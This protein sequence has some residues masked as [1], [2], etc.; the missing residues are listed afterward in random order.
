M[1]RIPRLSGACI[2][3]PVTRLRR[4]KAFRLWS[5]KH[6]YIIALATPLFINPMNRNPNIQIEFEY[7]PSVDRIWWFLLH[8]H[9][10]WFQATSQVPVRVCFEVKTM[11]LLAEEINKCYREGAGRC[12]HFVWRILWLG[13]R[14]DVPLEYHSAHVKSMLSCLLHRLKIQRR[15]RTISFKQ[16]LIVSLWKPMIRSFPTRASSFIPTLRTPS[17]H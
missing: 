4:Y 1:L 13:P 16:R 10:S 5:N 14:Q 17:K 3:V 15:E 7:L 9:Y 12:P 2:G 11:A 8:S 6:I